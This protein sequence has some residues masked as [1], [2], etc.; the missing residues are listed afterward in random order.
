MAKYLNGKELPK[1]ITYR[2]DGRYMGRFVYQGEQFVFYDTDLKALTKEMQEKRYE[3]E[4][5]LYSKE[6]NITVESWFKIWMEEYKANSVKYG[7]I[8]SYK[9]VYKKYIKKSL[10]KRRL[11]EI[12][13]EQI[14][15][16][17]NEMNETFSR[18]TIKLVIV[19]LGGMYKQA[20]KNGIVQRNPIPLTSMPRETKKKE[21]RVLSLNEQKQFIE[22][23]A[24]GRF[25]DLYQVAL[26]TGMRV[27][28]LRALEWQDIDFKN[29]IIHVT[30]T[31]KH[32]KGK[33]YLKDTPKTRSSERDI[34][35]LDSVYSVLKNR[36]R[37]QSEQRLSLGE[38][39]QPHPGLDRLVFTNEF[40]HPVCHDGLNQD[41]KRIEQSI[42]EAGH[43]FE[44]ITPHT[45]RHTFATRGLENGIK[46]KVM[47]ELLGHTSITMTMDIYSHVLPDTKAQE[48]QKLANLF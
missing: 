10:G 36:K 44:H 11:A 30:G 32:H 47:Q 4:H 7:T 33:G 42:R 3:V 21:F 25:Y 19:V 40:G 45:L 31:L 18:S 15:K 23:A 14:Q 41:I 1:G 5:G 22:A 35:M 26:N 46:P 24:D 12:R 38:R 16:L 43:S 48:I 29:R 6:S 34:P 20:L 8:E 2:S 9:E 28:E 37:Q 13:P 17:I 27:G 39:W